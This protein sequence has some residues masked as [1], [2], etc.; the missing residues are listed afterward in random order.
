MNPESS[1]ATPA[2]DAEWQDISGDGGV[3]KKA[4][5]QVTFDCSLCTTVALSTASVL[6]WC[7]YT[8]LFCQGL[9]VWTAMVER[10]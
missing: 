1:A 7:M 5:V 6:T 9:C 10:L 2:T 8:D 3:L 4:R